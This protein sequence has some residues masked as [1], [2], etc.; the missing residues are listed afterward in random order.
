MQ[1]ELAEPAPPLTHFDAQA[2]EIPIS[3]AT[4]AIGRRRQRCTSRSRPSNDNGALR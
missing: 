1:A 4:C 2:R 3:A